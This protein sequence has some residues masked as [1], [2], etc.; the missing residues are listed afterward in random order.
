MTRIICINDDFS[1][2]HTAMYRSFLHILKCVKKD[3]IYTL[4]SDTYYINNIQCSHF[5]D[6][7]GA[8]GVFNFFI[9]TENFYNHFISIAEQRE[10][11]I[12]EILND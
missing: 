1:W 5:K 11:R 7:I 12:N 9:E 10:N 4:I 6:G 2:T 8:A 3:N